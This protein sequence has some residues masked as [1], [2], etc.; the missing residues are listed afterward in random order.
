MAKESL[1]F[2]LVIPAKAGIH[3]HFNPYFLK[4]YK[5]Q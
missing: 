3:K 2:K 1:L 5:W 4:S